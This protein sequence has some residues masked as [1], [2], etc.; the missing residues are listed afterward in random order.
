MMNPMLTRE[1]A[2]HLDLIYQQDQ[3]KIIVH[4]GVAYRVVTYGNDEYGF[5]EMPDLLETSSFGTEMDNLR[6][7]LPPL[8]IGEKYADLG[9][10]ID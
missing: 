1:E 6:G 10:I 5:A 2:P 3:G 8:E 4:Q 9:Q 7:V